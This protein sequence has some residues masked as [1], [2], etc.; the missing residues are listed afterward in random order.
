MIASALTSFGVSVGALTWNPNDMAVKGYLPAA[1]TARVKRYFEAAPADALRVLT[2][3]PHPAQPLGV[4]DRHADLVGVELDLQCEPQ[5]V[6]EATVELL[7]V[8][9]RAKLADSDA[10]D[11]GLG[12]KASIR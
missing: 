3:V 2:V 8:S 5:R 6:Q 4:G 10:L 12:H 11:G 1:E 7:Q 9:L